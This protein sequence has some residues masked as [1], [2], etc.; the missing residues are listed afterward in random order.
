MFNNFFL[1]SINCATL[2][3]KTKYHYMFRKRINEILV[4]RKL[5]TKQGA[6]HIIGI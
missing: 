3:F 6:I 2:F 4:H 1:R 5:L